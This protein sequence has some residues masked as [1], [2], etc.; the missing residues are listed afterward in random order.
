[1]KINR[2]TLLLYHEFSIFV[3]CCSENVVMAETIEENVN[4]YSNH[5]LL[6]LHLIVSKNSMIFHLKKSMIL[7]CGTMKCLFLL[8]D[9]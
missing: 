1:M 9:I 5:I 7:G 4:C 8:S 2:F 3:I 6:F